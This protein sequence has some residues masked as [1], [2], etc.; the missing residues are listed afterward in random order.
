M[1]VSRQL[2]ESTKVITPLDQLNPIP[3]QL[4][5]RK[6][7]HSLLPSSIMGSAAP[8][9]GKPFAESNFNVPSTLSTRQ[10]NRNLPVIFSTAEQADSD[11]DYRLIG[12]TDR[13]KRISRGSTAKSNFES[14]SLDQSRDPEVVRT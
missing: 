1:E 3:P 14:K 4:Q 6:L 10:M 8:I 11:C 2:N 9:S 13:K 5:Q 7:S 12:H